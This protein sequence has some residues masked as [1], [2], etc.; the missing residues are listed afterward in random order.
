MQKKNIADMKTWPQGYVYAADAWKDL[1]T[2]V[3]DMVTEF[4][5]ENEHAGVDFATCGEISS[6]AIEDINAWCN[7]RKELLIKDF[8]LYFDIPE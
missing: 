7:K 4:F 3:T 2:F 8:K 6:D 1:M 5:G